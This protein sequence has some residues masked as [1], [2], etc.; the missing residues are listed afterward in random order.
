MYSQILCSRKPEAKAFKCWVTHA[1]LPAIRRDGAYIKCDERLLE[2]ANLE[3]L[4]ARVQEMQARAAQS[5]VFKTQRSA[6][7]IEERAA[8]YEALKGL[9]QGRR[10]RKRRRVVIPAGEV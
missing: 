6:A 5:V 7:S 8:R 1:V 9:S 4:Q 10:P 2:A 3:E